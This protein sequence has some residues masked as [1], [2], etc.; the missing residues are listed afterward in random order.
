MKQKGSAKMPV[1]I[2][3]FPPSWFQIKTKDKIM[4]IDPAWMRTYFT[5]YPKKIEFSRWPDPI[6]GLPEELE[7]A[8]LIILTHHHKD[9]C[10]SVTVNRLKD[11]DTLV[12]APKRCIKEL[13]KDINVVAPGDELTFGNIILKA[14]DAY[15]T[16]QGSSTRKVHHKG[17]GVGY[18]ITLEDKT[19]Y[20]AGDTDFIPEM[21]E[22]G[23]VD[24]ALLPIGG[25]FTMD[26]QDAVDAV[27]AIQPKVV[28]P[29]H[30]LRA[31]PEEFKEKVEA[32]SD[33]L[34]VP[35][36]MGEVYHLK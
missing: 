34:V 13:G 8:D 6:D 24:V 36:Q 32:K 19:I 7:K 27:I 4:Y 22:L 21:G 28:I 14:V 11:A 3:W 30:Y 31:D 16:E 15:N 29:M 26:I 5:K 2:K 25:T 1:S 12:V 35:L 33:I 20:H 23:A 17:L 18:L 10:K 9:H